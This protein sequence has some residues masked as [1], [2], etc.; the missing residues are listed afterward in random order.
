MVITKHVEFWSIPTSPVIRPTS[1]NSYLSYLY[2]WLDNAFI[3]DVY[4][5]RLF[6]F[7]DNAMAYY[8]MAVLPA[9]VCAHTN[10]D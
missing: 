7:N 2:F 4:M 5:T 10:T 8:A 6:L 1:L 9:D 3:G